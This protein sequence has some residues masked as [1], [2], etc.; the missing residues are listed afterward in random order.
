MSDSTTSKE[1]TDQPIATRKPI[2]LRF[3]AIVAVLGVAAYFVAPKVMEYVMF[4]QEKGKATQAP[5]FNNVPEGRP[6]APV[7][8]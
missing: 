4:L 3:L 7:S 2:S 5:T 1:T 6:P 8:E